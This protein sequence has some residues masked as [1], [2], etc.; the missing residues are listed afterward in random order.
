[1]A[2]QANVRKWCAKIGKARKKYEDEFNRMRE[3]MDF[4]Y[5]LQ[6]KGQKNLRY[7]K[8]VVNL[9]L[10]AINQGVAALYARDPKVSAKRRKRLDFKLWD[11]KL[12]TIMQAAQIVQVGSQIGMPIPPDI[13]AMLQDFQQGR[14]KQALIDKVGK[15]LEVLTQ[16]QIDQQS[17]R[18]K[19]QMKQLVR[20]VRTCGVG[21][22][23][24]LF[25]RDYENEL[26]PRS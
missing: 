17:P 1:M 10:R 20:R 7:P 22:I 23:K 24:V 8:Y 19:T 5:G 2:R 18:F 26:T 4:V 21:Y 12:E 25:C 3:N 6:W 14:M 13:M 11:E 9:T 16:Y 15:T